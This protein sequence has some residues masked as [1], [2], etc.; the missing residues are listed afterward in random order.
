MFCILA[1]IKVSYCHKCAYDQRLHING[2]RVRAHSTKLRAFLSI[3]ITLGLG[4]G[5][6]KL[7]FCPNFS[8]AAAFERHF[9]GIWQNAALTFIGDMSI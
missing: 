1:V 7:G 5:F 6:R 8:L 3:L 4:T 2:I 9:S